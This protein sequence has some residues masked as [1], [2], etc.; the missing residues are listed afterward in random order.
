[1]HR[2]R[3]KPLSVNEAYMGRKR[4]TSKYRTYE[5]VL[6]TLLPEIKVPHTGDLGLKVTWGFSSAASDIDNPLKPFLD[7]LQTTYGFNDKRITEL[8]VNK[9]RTDKGEEFIEFDLYPRKEDC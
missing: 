1:M 6:P 4:K 7:V 8:I 3:I 2:C 5:V 9:V